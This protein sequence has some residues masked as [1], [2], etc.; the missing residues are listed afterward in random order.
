MGASGE[1]LTDDGRTGTAHLI[2]GGGRPTAC[3]MGRYRPLTVRLS[4]HFGPDRPRRVQSPP[5]SNRSRRD[6]ASRAEA[7]RRAR[8]ASQG[9]EPEPTDDQSSA[10][11]NSRGAAPQGGFLQR[12]FPPAPPLRGKPDPLAGFEY[13]GAARRLVE[14]VY[15][16]GRNPLVWLAM[17]LVF[18]VAYLA[19]L[20]FA[21]QPIGVIASIASFVALIAAGWIGWQRPWAYGLAAS[22][23]GYAVF[24]IL[25]LVVFAR[26]PAQGDKF[27]LSAFLQYHVVNGLLQAVIGV[28][29][30]FYGGYLRRRMAEP[31]PGTPQRRRR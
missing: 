8:S 24:I 10:A 23:F 17:G 7:R 11:A 9:V 13:D 27:N 14:T 21:Q 20:M 28:V 3:P 25:L 29:A 15:L 26:I 30:G 12:I 22:I 16:L 4:P 19:M 31:R 6:P 1:R 2:V 5:M 18:G